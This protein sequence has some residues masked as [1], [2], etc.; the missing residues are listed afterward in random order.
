M[1]RLDSDSQPQNAQNSL[2]FGK[3]EEVEVS[4]DDDGFRGA[5]Y[6]ATIVESP[7][8]A[9]GKS[10][11]SKKRRKIVIEYKTLVKED[12]S[13]PLTELVDPAYV[14]PLPPRSNDNLVFEENDVVDAGYRDGW[15]NGIVRK[16]L[17]G[18]RYRVYFDNPPDVIDFDGKDLR[19]H[20]DWVNGNWVSPEKQQTTG[21]IFS[22]GTAI[23]VNIDKE[24]FRDAWFPA[25]VIKENGDDTFL[26]KYQSSGNN[27]E[28]GTKVNVDSLHIRPVP[29][30]YADRN[31][32]LL[33]KVDA[34]YDCCWRSGLITKLLAGRRF[35][36]Y[37][38]H[39]NVEKELDYSKI[40][41]HAEW[42]DGQWKCKYK[43][44]FQEVMVASDDKRKLGNVH[45]HSDKPDMSVRLDRSGA[46]EG[47]TEEKVPCS[48]TTRNL[49][50]QSLHFNE[51]IP[52]NILPPSKKIKLAAPNNTGTHSC[53]SRKSIEEDAV[54]VPLSVAALPLTKMPIETPTIETLRGLATRTTGGRRTRFSKKPVITER[55]TA[56]TE[57]TPAGKT[58]LQ[59]VPQSDIVLI[60]IKE[61]PEKSRQQKVT[62]VKS[63]SSDIVTRKWR[64]T[65]PPF[66]SPQVSAAVY[67]ATHINESGKKKKKGAKVPLVLALEAKGTELQGGETLKL[68]K[69]QMNLNDSAG[70]KVTGL[71][72]HKHGSSQRR[73]RGRP[74]KLVTISRMASEAGKE[75]HGIE[76]VA[77]EIVLKVQ[78]TNEVE[79]PTQT[80][81]EFTVLFTEKT[82]GV[83][84]TDCLTKEVD[85][86]VT[87]GSKAVVDDDQP[88]STWI[89][90]M[91]SSVSGEE[92]VLSSGRSSCGW[93]EMRERHVD[94]A[95]VSSVNE[96]QHD[97]RADRN[98]C[99][100]FVKRSLVWKTIESMEIFRIMP[101]KPHFHPLADC[102]EEYR[103][104]SAIGIMVTFASLFEKIT[105]LRL[106]DSESV[107]L[108]TLESLLDLEKH[109]FDVTM[110]RNR[111]KELLLIKNGKEEL[112]NETK[113]V[114]K[115]IR[116]HTDESGNLDAKIKDIEKKIMEL[117]EELAT[118]KSVMETKK[119]SISRLQLHM[120]SLNTRISN[121]RDSF[122]KIASAPWKLP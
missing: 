54:D 86:A 31:F 104:G 4:S 20:W 38:K 12:G 60:R 41:P 99:L 100:P 101:Q 119:I 118:S 66:R 107:L 19:P 51:K 95:M 53:S 14:R 87:T 16:V 43:L 112:L 48:T 42:I 26:V 59:A 22:S 3:G 115:Q 27:D 37:F 55:V 29:P 92:L 117:Q 46:T 9:A 82:A 88:L 40:R 113:D 103:E 65:K 56:K 35:K 34:Q 24:N 52:S 63:Q 39:G 72:Q 102:K 6:V 73:K 109:G 111:V 121:A 44:L 49:L 45:C 8:A 69:D 80:R 90:G 15:W 28:A 105:S 36:I 96:I 84:E 64:L 74:R 91:H 23:E 97:C 30:H 122:D 33:E 93:D 32:E 78:P 50:E 58:N 76:D 94:R 89:G 10:S 62:E 83:L 47:R 21:S 13:T 98:E 17:D 79:L 71:N 114:E 1:V 2:C 85:M 61:L 67:A 57:N 77:N 7:A 5:W 106:D 110:P 11:A 108:S 70:D 81:V 120:H 116:E 75:D 25:V 68:M 18:S